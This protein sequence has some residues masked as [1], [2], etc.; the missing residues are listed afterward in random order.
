MD[1]SSRTV[2]RAVRKLNPRHRLDSSTAARDDQA[3]PGALRALV[4]R[5]PLSGANI[6]VI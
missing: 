6:C 2:S 3:V 1:A 5:Y 4:F